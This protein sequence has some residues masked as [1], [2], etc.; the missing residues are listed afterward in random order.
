P[1]N[2]SVPLSR[3]QE[4]AAESRAFF[5]EN[6]NEMRR[7]GVYSTTIFLSLKGMFGMEPII[8]WPDRLNP[9]RYETALP[10]MQQA[11]GAAEARPEARAYAV[12]LRRRLVARLERL[13]P[14][15][16]QIGK[17]YPYREAVSGHAGWDV[18]ESL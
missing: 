5:A 18:L 7:H 4:L 8:Y 15:H 11:F 9:L 6:A 1:S 14:A 10:S 12:D 17:F 13:H 2:F 3:G 16:F